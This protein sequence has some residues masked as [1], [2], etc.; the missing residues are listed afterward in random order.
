[1]RPKSNQ[2]G[3]YFV[4]AKTHKFDSVNDITLDKLKLHP[5]ID[6]TGTCIY[7]ASKV[8]AKYLRPLFKNKYSIDDTL[9]FPNLL[10][11]AEESDDYK[12][13]SYHVESLFI[14]ITVNETIDH[15]IQK[16]FVKKKPFCKKSI[17]IKLLKKL[18]QECGFTVRY[19]YGERR[20]SYTS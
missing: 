10:K 4:T 12:D 11:N 20:Y 15:I 3:R 6:K 1:M 9:A 18:T 2:P 5:I 14:G 8:V 17:F 13:V 16:I 7:N 19:S